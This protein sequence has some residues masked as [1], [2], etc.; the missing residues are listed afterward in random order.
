MLGE[1]MEPACPN[2]DCASAYT[3]YSVLGS[4][5]AAQNKFDIRF[6]L[7]GF[8]FCPRLRLVGRDTKRYDTFGIS[9]VSL[10]PSRLPGTSRFRMQNNWVEAGNTSFST[11][12]I[13]HLSRANDAHTYSAMQPWDR[14]TR[15]FFERF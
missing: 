10:F 9:A 8:L 2:A 5:T 13:S 15:K 14:Q 4:S 12:T 7:A 1:D 11:A 6:P 3:V